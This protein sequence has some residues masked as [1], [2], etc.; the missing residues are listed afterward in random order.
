MCRNANGHITLI[1][2]MLKEKPVILK[3]TTALRDLN[4]HKDYLI[5]TLLLVR[6]F[7]HIT[8]FLIFFFIY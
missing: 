5:K 8:V 3:L 2:V 6:N 7:L 4:Q 1:S